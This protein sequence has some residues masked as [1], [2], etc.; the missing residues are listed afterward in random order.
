M[1]YPIIAIVG[2]PNVGKSTLFNRLIKQNKAI[3]NDFAGV[4]RDRNYGMAEFSN[5]KFIV[6]DTGGLESDDSDPDPMQENIKQQIMFAINEADIIL[7]LMDAKD[8]L[9][10]TDRDIFKLLMAASKQII[11]VVN[12]VDNE[13]IAN[14]LNDFYELGIENFLPI[15]AAHGKG[16]RELN[17][18]IF[19][20]FKTKGHIDKNPENRICVS[21]IGR[22]NV[23]KSSLLNSILRQ[24]RVVVSPEPGTTRDIIDTPFQYNNRKYLL[25]DTAGIRRRKNIKE[26]LEKLFCFKAIKNVVSSDVV[27]IVID[28]TSGVSDQD[29]RIGSYVQEAFK[30]AIIVVNKWDLINNK[31]NKT[32]RSFEEAIR[33]KFKYLMF[34]PIIFTSCLTGQRVYN[35]FPLIEKIYDQSKTRVSTS[36]LNDV[37][38][39]AISKASPP[40]YKG[41]RIKFYYQT[42]VSA[43]PPTFVLFVNY[44]K[45]IHFSYQRYLKNRIREHLNFEF[46]PIQLL[47]RSKDKNAGL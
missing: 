6:I 27:L 10:P 47:F 24:D 29:Q 33:N 2:R 11:Y 21:I 1:S 25:L 19:S 8:G 32:H 26:K 23:G 44:P 15:A 39:K 9:M 7:Y 20:F 28:A 34:A 43:S 4:T 35:I 5:R 31:D 45:G 14:Q 42:Q 12:K 3:V 46:A 13:Q 41:K 18:K 36:T 16:M 17:D 30:P 40:A 38:F 37:I 22:P